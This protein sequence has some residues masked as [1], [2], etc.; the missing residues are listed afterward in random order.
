[1]FTDIGASPPRA[2]GRKDRSERGK[3]ETAPRPFFRRTAE[4]SP[5][6]RARP[7]EPDG[8]HTTPHPFFLYMASIRCVTRKPPKMFTLAR[9]KAKKPDRRA[10]QP[11][12][13]SEERRVGKECRSRWSPY[14]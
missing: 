5:L 3:G 9:V 12:P 13:G 6:G 14:H 10:P 1:M 8:G 4:P 2:G 11:L 7:K